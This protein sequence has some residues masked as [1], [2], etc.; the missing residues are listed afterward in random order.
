M[1]RL[2]ICRHGRTAWNAVQRL[3]GQR[4]VDLDDTGRV[5]AKRAARILATEQPDVLISSDLLRARNT[6]TE[7]GAASGLPVVTDSRL[8]EVG[9]GEWE[10]LAVEQIAQR[11]PDEHLRWKAGRQVRVDGVEDLDQV[12]KRMLEALTE[13][14]DSA[15]GGTVVAVGHGG[16]IKHGLA[17]LLGWPGEV[18]RSLRGLSNCH[19]LDLRL[20]STGWR[21]YGYNLG[22][23]SRVDRR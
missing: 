5:E 11:Y 19:W 21:L 9:Y 22:A 4:D 1:S 18:A 6:A 12:T 3:Q 8:R 23:P 20:D 14:A 2:L 10:G 16:S 13:A 15:P 17:A 7:I